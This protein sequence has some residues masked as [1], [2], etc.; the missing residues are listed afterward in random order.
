MSSAPAGYLT[1]EQY[2]EQ[3]RKSSFKSECY[4]GETLAMAGASYRHSIILNNLVVTV[5]QLLRPSNCRVHSSDLRLR[6]SSTGLYTYPDVM[7]ICGDPAFA[8][9]QHDTVLNPVVIIEVL[10]DST[11]DYDRGRKFQH[12]RALASLTDYLTIAHAEVHVEHYVR[13]SSGQWLLS[14]F[15]DL[16]SAATLMSINTKLPLSEIY[17]QIEFP[18]ATAHG[19]IS[20]E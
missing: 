11:K 10:S 13:Q 7:V 2:L 15:N 19:P 14:E 1:P 9:D 3:E 4:R 18:D 20:A 6:V 5:S 17:F 12:Y 8:D 16:D